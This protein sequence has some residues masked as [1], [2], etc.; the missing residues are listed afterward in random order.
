MSCFFYSVLFFSLPYCCFAAPPPGR[1]SSTAA[2]PSRLP[3][4][5]RAA[6]ALL[7]PLRAP[8]P[9]PLIGGGSKARR[10]ASSAAAPEATGCG[11]REASSGPHVPPS[12]R[13]RAELKSPGDILWPLQRGLPLWG[14]G[15]RHC[16]TCGKYCRTRRSRDGEPSGVTL[17]A[18][19]RGVSSSMVQGT[20]M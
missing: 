20:F 1:G 14:S 15:Y 16:S 3:L 18:R 11:G 6:P 5:R 8:Q 4:P 2:V 9:A 19:V 13:G 7:A 12:G 10:R 17:V